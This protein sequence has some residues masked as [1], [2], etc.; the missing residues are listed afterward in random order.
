MA[1]NGIRTRDFARNVA[2]FI[3]I[4]NDAQ[5]QVSTSTVGAQ[6]AALAEGV[7]DVWA[8]V[9]SYIKVAASASDVTTTT[10][11]LLRANQTIPLWVSNGNKIGAVLASGTDT[12]RYHR[13]A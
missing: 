5:G 10:G 2:D 6:S 4:E 9:D 1:K 3:D 11:Y 7:Y 8:T 12:L 13:V